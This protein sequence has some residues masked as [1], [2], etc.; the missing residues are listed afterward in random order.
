[1][2]LGALLVNGYGMGIFRALKGYGPGDRQDKLNLLHGSNDP[3]NRLRRPV[4]EISD[5]SI[6]VPCLPEKEI[7]A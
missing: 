3:A 4:L 6:V 5:S 2:A 7:Y 1:M